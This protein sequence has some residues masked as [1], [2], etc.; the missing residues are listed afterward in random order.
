MPRIR[1]IFHLWNL[2]VGKGVTVF[3]RP[4]HSVGTIE[5][6]VDGKHEI[7]PENIQKR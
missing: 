3:G 6:Q 1:G 4:A 7:T 2:T 5:V